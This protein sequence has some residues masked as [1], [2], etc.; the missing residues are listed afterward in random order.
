[1][2]S[3]AKG[4]Q[5][6]AGYVGGYVWSVLGKTFRAL[7]TRAAESLKSSRI[8]RCADHGDHYFICALHL[9]TLPIYILISL[10]PNRGR[11]FT[12]GNRAIRW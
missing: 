5:K 9:R 12:S 4:F 6:N 3:D 2:R 7:A 10:M 1:M 8:I 11:C